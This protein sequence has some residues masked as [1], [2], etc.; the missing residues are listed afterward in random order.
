MRSCI[1]GRR[2]TMAH[3]EHDVE[4]PAVTIRQGIARR[5]TAQDVAMR[6]GGALQITGGTVR[7]SQAG[8]GIAIAEK[9][10]PEQAAAQAVLASDRVPRMSWRAV[11]PRSSAENMSTKASV[12]CIDGMVDLPPA[13]IGGGRLPEAAPPVPA[14]IQR[15]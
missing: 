1:A 6:Q 3:E 4:A 2:A 13:V 5:V 12:T 10:T 11:A 8:T 9:A 14:R 15:R 7:L